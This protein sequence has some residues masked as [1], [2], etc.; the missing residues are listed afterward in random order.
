MDK[1][2]ILDKLKSIHKILFTNN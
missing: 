1:Q 2:I